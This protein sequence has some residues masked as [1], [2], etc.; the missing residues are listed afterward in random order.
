MFREPQR[1]RNVG[2]SLVALAIMTV[3]MGPAVEG[4]ESAGAARE[5][6]RPPEP[7]AR[8]YTVDVPLAPMPDAHA[9][10]HAVT[11][12]EDLRAASVRPH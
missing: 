6:H 12:E 8:V 1:R 4:S 7:R 3:V 2:P 10:G 11:P 9:S 5:S